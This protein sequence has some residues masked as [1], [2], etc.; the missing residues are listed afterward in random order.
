[1]KRLYHKDFKKRSGKKTANPEKQNVYKFVDNVDNSMDN[2]SWNFMET[3]QNAVKSK[4]I[5][6]FLKIFKNN[7]VNIKI[8]IQKLMCSAL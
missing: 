2:F 4:D 7:Y 6:E 8:H 3:I 5:K 1:M